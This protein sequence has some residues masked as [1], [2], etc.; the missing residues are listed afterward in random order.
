MP[1]P[2]MPTRQQV[3]PMDISFTV[4]ISEWVDETFAWDTLSMYVTEEIADR[5]IFVI[6]KGMFDKVGHSVS[7]QTAGKLTKNEID[8]AKNWIR[9]QGN[10]HDTLVMSPKQESQFWRSGEVWEASRIPT[11]Y[12]PEKDRGPN[13]LGKIAG[14]NT[15]V[16]FVAQGIAIVYRKGEIIFT[17]T[18]LEIN[19]DDMQRPRNLVIKRRC[20]S[21]PVDEKAVVKIAL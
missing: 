14:L 15:Y 2:S 13:Y 11:G 20:S 19:F 8:Q 3:E 1:A 10:Y 9:S 6:L 12:V 18:P 5:E 4:D 17:K 7:A 16:T 21:A